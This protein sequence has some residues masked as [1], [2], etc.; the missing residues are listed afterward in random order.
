M[1]LNKEQL[2]VLQTPESSEREYLLAALR[3]QYFLEQDSLEEEGLIN[4]FDDF[5]DVQIDIAKHH[6]ADVK[7][8]SE[9]L[10]QAVL[11]ELKEKCN[12]KKK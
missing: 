5:V 2:K 11:E 10:A 6:Y 7:P 3:Y 9:G 4:S 12:A 1:Y 8:T